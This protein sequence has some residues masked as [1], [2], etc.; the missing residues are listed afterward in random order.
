MALVLHNRRARSVRYMD[1][2]SGPAEHETDFELQERLAMLAE[3]ERQAA[4][5]AVSKA[6]ARHNRWWSIAGLVMSFRLWVTSVKLRLG[7]KLWP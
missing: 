4:Y 5:A 7:M 6:I 3:Q 2:V 1:D